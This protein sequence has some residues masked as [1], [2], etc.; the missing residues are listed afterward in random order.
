MVK[1]TRYKGTKRKSENIKIERR[2]GIKRVKRM[3]KRKGRKR[4]SR[5]KD[6]E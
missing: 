2:E 3:G 1:I 4:S 6:K 5:I